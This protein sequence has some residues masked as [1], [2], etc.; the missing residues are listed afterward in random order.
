[1]LRTHRHLLLWK[2][3]FVRSF[4]CSLNH[5]AYSG[6]L[7]ERFRAPGLPLMVL[8]CKSDLTKAVDPQV[9][10]GV[11]HQYD[12]GL[13]E[14]TAGLEEGKAKMRRSFDWLL[15]SIF[16]EPGTSIQCNCTSHGS[17]MR[18]QN[19]KAVANTEI[20]RRP[21]IFIIL[22]RGR[23]RDLQAQHLPLCRRWRP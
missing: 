14:V 22:Y 5:R 1:M 21:T 6:S 23:C 17:Y 18:F 19:T 11:L 3:S 12:V 4:D 13:V 20:L 2:N 16:R 9:A 7:V 10:T 8:A 15:R